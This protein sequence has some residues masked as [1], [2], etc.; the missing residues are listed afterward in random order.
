M[1]GT[2]FAAERHTSASTSKHCNLEE[3]TA[4]DHGVAKQRTAHGLQQDIGR[5]LQRPNA[6]SR[7]AALDG[8]EHD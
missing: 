3:N 8:Q 6:C 1:E 7:Y 4:I 2:S 5:R